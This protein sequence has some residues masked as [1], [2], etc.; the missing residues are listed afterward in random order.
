[1]IDIKLL[2]PTGDQYAQFSMNGSWLAT[3]KAVYAEAVNKALEAANRQ[4]ERSHYK[5]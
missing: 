1:M 3:T 4:R 2:G 5:H